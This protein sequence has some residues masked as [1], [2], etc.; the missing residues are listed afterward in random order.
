M[1]LRLCGGCQAS[2]SASIVVV[3]D[4]PQPWGDA[5]EVC[6]VIIL[7]I[8]WQLVLLPLLLALGMGLVWGSST[9]SN[10]LCN[11][12]TEVYHIFELARQP[13]MVL[14]LLLMRHLRQPLPGLARYRGTNNTP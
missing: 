5:G 2:G 13:C 4:V 10:S 12:I 9:A 8:G 14:L 11:I 6:P 1:L 7:I 3:G